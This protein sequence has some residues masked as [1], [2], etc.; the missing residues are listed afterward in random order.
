MANRKKTTLKKTGGGAQQ[1]GSVESFKRQRDAA[2]E[3]ML[4]A[5]ESGNNKEYEKQYKIYR[6]L[7]AGASAA[8][9]NTSDETLNMEMSKN[10][11]RFKKKRR[12]SKGGLAGSSHTDYRKKGLFR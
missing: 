7:S 12:F 6:S 10:R 3:R 9:G 8:R 5:L 2:F 11:E 4:A 1:T